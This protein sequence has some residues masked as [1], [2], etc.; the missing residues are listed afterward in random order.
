MVLCVCLHSDVLCLCTF[1]NHNG[2]MIYE[3]WLE[4]SWGGDVMP[5]PD[6]P[7]GGTSGWKWGCED[8]PGLLSGNFTCLFKPRPRQEADPHDSAASMATA[9]LMMAHPL[10]ES[11]QWSREV[12]TAESWTREH[13]KTCACVFVSMVVGI[14]FGCFE[15]IL[16]GP[17]I[18]N[19]GL[20]WGSWRG[21]LGVGLY[22][23]Y[24]NRRSDVDAKKKSWIFFINVVI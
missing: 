9:L 16:I 11:F 8:Q 4:Q 22:E 13:R 19:K 21:F 17:H 23:L 12:E 10:P 15:D 24:K 20:S 18:F 5:G 14:Q 6:G 1:T 2:L 3:I 7:A